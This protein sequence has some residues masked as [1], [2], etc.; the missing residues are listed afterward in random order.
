MF[1]QNRLA[2]AIFIVAATLFYPQDSSADGFNG[3][4]LLEWSP[5]NQRFY[6]QTSVS[7]AGV[8]V[9]QKDREV[10]RCLDEWG[11]QQHQRKYEAILKAI[12]EYPTYHPQGVILALL[13][14]ACGAF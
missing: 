14:K 2:T 8:I 10:A 13:R 4:L 1:K 6:F 5:G 12:R 3:T 9:A 7:M 11:E